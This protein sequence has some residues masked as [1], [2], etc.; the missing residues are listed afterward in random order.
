MTDEEETTAERRRRALIER[1]GIDDGD[2][3]D[4]GAA[5]AEAT[6]RDPDVPV[7]AVAEAE[8]LT[9]L[10]RDAEARGERTGA[11][12]ERHDGPE[13]AAVYRERRDELL[14][15]HGYTGRHREGD[16]TLVL[17]PAEWVVDGTVQFDRIDD[18]DRAVEVALSGP[19][20]GD[21]WTTVE[22]HNA[23]LVA[24]VREEYG[25]E[26]A[27]NARA[28]ADFMGNHYA[29]VVERATADEIREFLAE[30]YPRNAW[31]TEAEASLVEES[32]EKVYE[33][34][35]A[36]APTFRSER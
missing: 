18:T 29:K 30:Y 17:Y 16:D 35:G 9:R 22:A 24:T 11:A 3:N 4:G 33:V 31:P 5:A 15:A 7:D 19:G 1:T 23:Q 12:G 34:A 8:R 36:S 14:A 32:V 26:H 10:A 6:D 2:G 27:A 13:E 28:F 25:E 21:D 20:R